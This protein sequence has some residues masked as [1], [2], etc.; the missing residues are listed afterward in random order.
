[1]RSVIVVLFLLAPLSSQ[2]E[3]LLYQL[4]EDGTWVRFDLDEVQTSPEK[5][6]RRLSGLLFLRSVGRTFMEGEPCRWIEIECER[7]DGANQ[8][9]N[10]FKLLIPEKRLKAGESPLDHVVRGWYQQSQKARLLT[11]E[12]TGPDSPH[13]RLVHLARPYLQGPLQELKRLDE[14][15]VDPK[16]GLLECEH[17]EGWIQHK[18]DIHQTE[19]RYRLLLNEKAPFG[20][21]S[22]DID[23][24][25]QRNGQFWVAT[26]CSLKLAD[27]GENASS[28]LPEK[29]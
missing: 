29:N 12:I 23:V 24:T 21:V 6:E 1:M 20:V 14:K 2:A 3:G 22:A 25:V 11:F 26:K 13:A 15:I 18:H 16:L 27:F 28:A 9:H 4:P 19:A 17:V 7:V 5:P 10:V 8:H